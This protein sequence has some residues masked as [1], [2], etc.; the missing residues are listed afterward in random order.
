VS[1]VVCFK[2]CISR[3]AVKSSG[4]WE[5][6]HPFISGLPPGDTL[7]GVFYDMSSCMHQTVFSWLPRVMSGHRCIEFYMARTVM[8]IVDVSSHNQIY[9]EH[10][11]SMG[12]KYPTF[13][14]C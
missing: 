12:M 3:C 9:G 4:V 2:G 14:T 11:I 6:T 10:T 8:F 1:E 13:L 5:A 7:N